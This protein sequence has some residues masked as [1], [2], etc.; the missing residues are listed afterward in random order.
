[1]LSSWNTLTLTEAA[2]SSQWH[3]SVI[4]SSCRTQPGNSPVF[5]ARTFFRHHSIES[6]KA[7]Q[8]H[9]WEKWRDREAI[10]DHE[11]KRVAFDSEL[12]DRSEFALVS[13]FNLSFILRGQMAKWSFSKESCKHS[14]NDTFPTPDWFS[15]QL[16][17]RLTNRSSRQATNQATEFCCKSWQSTNQIALANSPVAT[18]NTGYS[19]LIS[20]RSTSWSIYCR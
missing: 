9:C 11:M 19:F 3:C 10:P 2:A 16:T 13:S 4:A 17:V 6:A 7:K 15:H 1:M 5:L 14:A 12:I 8:Q 20:K 18:T